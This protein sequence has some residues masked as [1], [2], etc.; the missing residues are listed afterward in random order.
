MRLLQFT[1]SIGREILRIFEKCE[2]KNKTKN[3][4]KVLKVCFF[5]IEKQTNLII[6]TPFQQYIIESDS[7]SVENMT[8]EIKHKNKNE[9]ENNKTKQEQKLDNGFY[10]CLAFEN[11]D[12]N[13]KNG[14]FN[15]CNNQIRRYNRTN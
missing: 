1:S 6:N 14:R 10:V 9:L 15:V 12:I 2:T 3:E 8:N 13:I 5:R 11:T 7:Q 4:R